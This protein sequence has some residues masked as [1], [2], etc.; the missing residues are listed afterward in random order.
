MSQDIPQNPGNFS[1]LMQAGRI[2]FSAG[3]RQVAHDLWR[4]A[5]K[6]D[7][8]NEQVWASLLEVLDSD[9]DKKVC[10]ENILAINSMNVQARRELNRITSQLERAAHDVVAREV[11]QEGR[12][13]SRRSLLRRAVLLGMAIGFSG[14]LFALVII[15]I[16]S[17]R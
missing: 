15:I 8:Y 12:Q 4:E 10:L 7:P 17:V 5:A 16:T 2:A 9:A 3:K 13:R 14:V 1:D 11:K 6:L